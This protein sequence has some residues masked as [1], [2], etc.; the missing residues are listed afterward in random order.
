[1]ALRI[2]G[3]A[4][5]HHLRAATAP[6]TMCSSEPRMRPP[7]GMLAAPPAAPSRSQ[8][9]KHDQAAL[10]RA[11]RRPLGRAPRRAS[12]PG[13]V[14]A[15]ATGSGCVASTTRTKCSRPA[16]IG[17]V[18]RNV[19]VLRSCGPAPI[20]RADAGAVGDAHLLDVGVRRRRA[21]RRSGGRSPDRS[22]SGSDAGAVAGPG[23]AVPPANQ[24]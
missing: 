17:D 3:N 16:G 12:G 19:V 7:P 2:V 6:L 14:G 18:E 8:R 5:L 10:A 4:G 9:I 15:R 11:A 1:M 21:R 22:R 24:L 13:D 23:A 20:S